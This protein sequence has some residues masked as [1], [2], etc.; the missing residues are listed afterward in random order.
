MNHHH[1]EVRADTYVDSVKLM[2]VSRAMR[3]MDGV[4][5]ATAVMATPANIELLQDE[6]IDAT[7]L[8]DAKSNDLV[9]A[10]L[11]ESDDEAETAVRS[12]L[13]E[14]R[15]GGG[16][17]AASVPNR[18]TAPRTIE[19]ALRSFGQ[20]N[21]AIVAVPGPYAALESYKALEQ[22]LH[23]LLFS[24][25]VPLEDEVG[26]KQLAADRGLL[27]MG[28]GAGTAMLGGA[29]LAFANV[30]REGP[31]RVVAAAGTGA[32]E[33]MTLLH[34]WGSGV[35]HVIGV[36]GQDVKSA[37]GGLMMR[38]AIRAT[39][40]RDE[41]VTL[42][43][44]KPPE[45]DV[46][47]AVLAE[48]DGRRA[49]CAFMGLDEELDPPEGVGI[50]RTL[51]EAVLLTLDALGIERPE[52]APGMRALAEEAGQRLAPERDAVRGVFSG[53]T[54]CFE[55]M[56]VLASRLGE[57][58]SNTP[59]RPGWDLPAPDGAHIC[60]DLG[61]EEYTRGKPHPM[62]DP[63]AREEELRRAAGQSS[64][65]VVLLD[66]VLGHGS[67]EDPAGALAPVLADIGGGSTSDGPT[68]IAYVLG[69]D[70]DPQHLSGQV[71]RLQEAGCLVAP[72]VARA[73]LLA[74]AVSSRRPDLLEEIP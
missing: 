35:S 33:V 34:R 24:D 47:R 9:L 39:S 48:L 70:D 46:A 40:D 16:S 49:V 19:T 38:S 22:G 72:T 59:L 10:A 7:A 5:W 43:V 20:A 50:A 31:V 30:V 53:G 13:E 14:L 23:V 26:L 65:A 4:F 18:K 45:P 54:M 58:R 66:V 57:I 28:P 63:L 29:G 42:V 32:Q 60:L 2:A 41:H 67:H 27:L 71:E 12:A 37:V 25:N 44:S 17:D 3:D 56:V 1:V 36:G 8:Q 64:T 62:I 15:G 61:E 74:A 55:S 69:T 52:P 51:E 6:G 68:V 21:T 11:A 73:A